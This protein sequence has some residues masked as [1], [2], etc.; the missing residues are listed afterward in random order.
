[1]ET[2]SCSGGTGFMSIISDSMPY[3]YKV[4]EPPQA[5]G[6]PA[7]PGRSTEVSV[8]LSAKIK[9]ESI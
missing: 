1:M 8:P 9:E 2:R 3:I 7:A 6:H 5:A 4:N